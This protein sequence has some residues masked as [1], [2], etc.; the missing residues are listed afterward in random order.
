VDDHTHTHTHEIKEKQKKTLVESRKAP[1]RD[2]DRLDWE[3]GGQRRQ[4]RA[5][6]RVSSRRELQETTT[7]KKN[8]AE[9]KKKRETQ[10]NAVHTDFLLIG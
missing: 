3:E 4:G 10:K 1:T 8:E 5:R 6:L 9:Q 2:W 7:K